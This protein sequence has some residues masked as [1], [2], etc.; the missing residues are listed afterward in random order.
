M[1]SQL[2][3]SHASPNPALLAA[4]LPLVL[5]A[6]LAAADDEEAATDAAASV[7]ADD[8]LEQEVKTRAPVAMMTDEMTSRALL[9]M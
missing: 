4:V 9:R 2:T 1:E 8:P 3:D 6:A 5:G 7:E